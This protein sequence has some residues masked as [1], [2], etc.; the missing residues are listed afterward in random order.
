LKW[1]NG[2]FAYDAV[3]SKRS[4]K[5]REQDGTLLTWSDVVKVYD[6]LTTSMLD[7][8]D[9]R[10][11]LEDHSANDPYESGRASRVARAINKYGQSLAAQIKCLPFEMVRVQIRQSYS[12]YNIY[13]HGLIGSYN[14]I[15]NL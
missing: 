15:G 7:P 2:R 9:I 14:L 11:L 12:E 1:G 5:V 8:D 13:S 10:W 3:N 6:P 4:H